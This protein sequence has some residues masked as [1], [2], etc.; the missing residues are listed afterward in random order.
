[1]TKFITL[2]IAAVIAAF[3]ALPVQAQPNA[4]EQGF[5]AF[6]SYSDLNLASAAG[7]RTHEH[8]I[9]AAADRTCGFTT[10]PGLVEALPVPSCRDDALHSAP[11]PLS[12]AVALKEH[13]RMPPDSPQARR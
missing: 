9:D 7:A 11:P 13:G 6:V 3:A 4:A 2:A 5:I 10:A 8:R 1:M 12:R